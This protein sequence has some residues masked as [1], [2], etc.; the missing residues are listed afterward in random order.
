[1]NQT[2]YLDHFCKTRVCGKEQWQTQTLQLSRMASLRFARSLSLVVRRLVKGIVKPLR[3]KLLEILTSVQDP[4]IYDYSY[5]RE[6]PSLHKSID[7]TKLTRVP[8][9]IHRTGPSGPHN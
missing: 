9:V 8:L 6:G 5:C 2:Q 1:M 7:K 4:H 3:I